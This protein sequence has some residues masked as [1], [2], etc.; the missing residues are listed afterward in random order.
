MDSFVL[1]PKDDPVLLLNAIIEGMDISFLYQ[2]Y[3]RFGRIEY[4]PK[5]LFKIL[6]YGY[7]RS[8]FSSH[9]LETACK[10]NTKFMFLL[11]G[12]SPPS[13]STLNRF[14]Q[15]LKDEFGQDLLAQLALQLEDAGLLSFEHVFI[16]GT[17]IE[18]NANRYSFVWRNSVEKNVRKLQVK[19]QKEL[20]KMLESYGIRYEIPE[21][22]H[23]DTLEDIL[24]KLAQIKEKRCI[25]FV[26]G[27][28]S[29]K[30]QLQRE[31]ETVQKWLDRAKEY[32]VKEATFRGRNS[33]S[34]TDTDATFMHMKE[35][36]M[37]NGQLK[38]GYNV[39]VATASGFI[40]GNY[41]SPDR[42]DVHTLIPFTERLLRNYNIG[43]VVVD[44][45]YE[46]EENYTYYEAIEDTELWVKPSNH[47]Q[48]K[49]RKYRNDISRKE[50]MEYDEEKDCYICAAEKELHPTQVKRQTSKS[51]YITETT[52]YSCHNC[53][54]C[55]M[56]ERCIKSKSQVPMEERSKNIY[57]SKTFQRQRDEME[58]KINSP[59]GKLLR[60]NR[61]IWAE[62]AFAFIKEDLLFRR[63]MLRGHVK[64]ETEWFLLSFAYN[65]LKL[66]HKVQNGRLDAG[67]IVPESF[68]P[69][70]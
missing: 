5:V 49:K 25:S 14:R 30:T 68:P 7:M 28:G 47:E 19:I 24:E 33:Y 13:A 12:M 40:I 2:A 35:D 65:V 62:G 29:C 37:R 64:V 39:N 34:K 9:A 38:P 15:K 50:N 18:A 10:E 52:I 70:L 16:D 60:V 56:K 31:F 55:P 48:K 53:T 45:G 69:G 51:G 63:F 41:I 59:M 36:H 44:S 57:V 26:H 66:H 43:N 6:A 61:S 27:K 32:E 23:S 4:S 20:P 22:V 8:I 46:S 42:N 1:I 21:E 58:E 3:S 67:L 17:K 54:G 11:E